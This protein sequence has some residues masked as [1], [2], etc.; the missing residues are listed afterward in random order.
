[1]GV[2]ED[3]AAAIDE[4]AYPRGLSAN[5]DGIADW[6]TKRARA[7]QRDNFVVQRLPIECGLVNSNI[8]NA[9]A[10]LQ[11]GN[12]VIGMYIGTIFILRDLFGVMLS[13]RDIL[14]HIGNASVERRLRPKFNI[15]QDTIDLGHELANPNRPWPNDPIRGDYASWLAWIARYFIFEHEFCHIFNGHL[16]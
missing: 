12:D 9:V 6:Y 7:L 2:F 13:H 16:D 14:Q 11:G 3:F 10:G 15:E 5:L 8:F 1:M 4:D